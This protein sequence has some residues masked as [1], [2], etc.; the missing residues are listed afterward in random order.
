MK[1]PTKTVKRK[2]KLDLELFA[3]FARAV[4]HVLEP[5]EKHTIEVYRPDDE[6]AFHV[7]TDRARHY[8]LHARTSLAVPIA[9]WICVA[10]Q[11]IRLEDEGDHTRLTKNPKAVAWYKSNAKTVLFPED[12]LQQPVEPAGLDAEIVL[13]HNAVRYLSEG[14]RE[15]ATDKF[16]FSVAHELVH[17]FDAMRIIVPAV[18]GWEAYW[19]KA[20]GGGS[21]SDETR[22]TAEWHSL[23]LDDYGSRHELEM[24]KEY[25]PTQAQR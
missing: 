12:G 18:M 4:A 17:A 22:V 20:L 10:C 11:R 3:P 9:E 13:P 19:Q 8:R 23:F 2:F 25:W 1:F 16:L 15:Q 14:D 6:T 5:L 21:R 24:I 7:A